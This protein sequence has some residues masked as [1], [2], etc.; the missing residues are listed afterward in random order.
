MNSVMRLATAFA[1]GAAVMYYLDP[2]TGRRRRAMA[3]DKSV[4]AGHDVKDFARNKG[5]QVVDHA[6]G[7]AARTRAQLA[8]E[9]VDDDVLRDRVRSR[10][11]HLVDHPIEVEVMDGRVVLSANMSTTRLDELSDVVSAMPGVVRVESRQTPPPSPE[12]TTAS[13]MASDRKA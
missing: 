7:A 1:A 11:G 3:H 4:A 13:R 2:Q 12:K 9:F 6:R 5:K 10:L 8:N